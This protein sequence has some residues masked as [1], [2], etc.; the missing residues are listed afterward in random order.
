MCC[1]RFTKS[2]SN[3]ISI[4]YHNRRTTSKMRNISDEE[5]VSVYV[6]VVLVSQSPSRMTVLFHNIIDYSTVYSFHKIHFDYLEEKNTSVS[7]LCGS[8]CKMR[9]SIYRAFRTPVSLCIG[10]TKRIPRISCC[11]LSLL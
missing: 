7:V 4:S 6:C 11:R 5:A 9:N 10:V 2:I 1:T 3:D 8:T